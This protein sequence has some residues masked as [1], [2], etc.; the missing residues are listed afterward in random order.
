MKIS[1]VEDSGA[2][3]KKTFL[4]KRN[5]PYYSQSYFLT[6]TKTHKWQSEEYRVLLLNA[7][8]EAFKIWEAFSL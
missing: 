4:I 8:N 5:Q 2:E 6:Y 1:V 3:K 7:Y